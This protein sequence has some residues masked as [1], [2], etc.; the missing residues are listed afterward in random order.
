VGQKPERTDTS[1]C[2]KRS[3]A[4]K[5]IKKNT[6]QQGRAVPINVQAQ[7][8]ASLLSGQF[9]TDAQIAT[10]VSVSRMTVS[11]IRAA[12]PE[13]ILL[14]LVTLKKERIGE[15]VGEF[16]E[17]SLESLKRIDKITSDSEWLRLQDATGLSMFYGVKAD[18]VIRLLE[19]IERANLE[20]Y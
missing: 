5:S 9:R 4:K 10:E 13:E 3:S 18:K 17:E 19:A 16:L 20:N 12:I 14:Q 8:I 7:I 11:R 2:E 15:L 1:H 6:G